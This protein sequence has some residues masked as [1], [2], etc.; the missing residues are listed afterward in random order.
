MLLLIHSLSSTAVKTA[1]EDRT[2]ASSYINIETMNVITYAWSTL[3]LYRL[4]KGTPGNTGVVRDWD[5]S[6]L[7]IFLFY[8]CQK[9]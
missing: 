3:S 8:V 4:V 9:P 5:V 1:F 6:L 7:F 2:W